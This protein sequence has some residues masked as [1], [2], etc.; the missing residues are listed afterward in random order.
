MVNSPCA[1]ASQRQHNT[2]VLVSLAT[3]A[4][5]RDTRCRNRR[6]KSTPFFWRRFLVRMSC[7][8]GTGFVCYQILIPI[9]TL[10]YSKPESGVHVIEIIIYNLF[11]FELSFGYNT[12]YNNSGRL[13]EFVVYVAFSHINFRRQKFSFQTC[14]LRINV[15]ASGKTY[16]VSGGALNCTQSNPC[17]DKPAPENGVDLW[18]RSVRVS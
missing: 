8:S 5:T 11:L 1:C 13:G 2:Y 15:S 16:T 18:R 17:Y 6:H 10:F 14:M 4:N 3:Q 9:R 7:K 12:R